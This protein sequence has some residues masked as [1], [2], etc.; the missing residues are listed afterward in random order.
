MRNTRAIHAMDGRECIFNDRR[1]LIRFRRCLSPYRRVHTPFINI[2]QPSVSVKHCYPDIFFVAVQRICYVLS[3]FIMLPM[4]VYTTVVSILTT[5]VLYKSQK[6]TSAQITTMMP[7][8]LTII[9][10]SSRWYVDKFVTKFDVKLNF[11][12]VNSKYFHPF[13]NTV[14]SI[15][16]CLF[17]N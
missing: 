1:R 16:K 11:S 10:I 13:S 15:L 17:Y 2:Q 9:R 3:A 7:E 4:R 8:P 12:P 14:C 6:S 5:L